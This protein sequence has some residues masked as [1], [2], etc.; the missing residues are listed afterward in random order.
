ME[1]RV[2]WKEGLAFEGRSQGFSVP[3]DATP[4]LGHYFGPSPK[5]LLVLALAGCAGMDVM[6]VLK[7]N[8]QFIDRFEVEANAT[9]TTGKHP[10]VF[11]S[12]DL[13]FKFQGS[14][15]PEIAT[16]AVEL[17]QTLYSGVS[18]MICQSAPINWILLINGE[19]RGQGRANFTKFEEIFQSTFEG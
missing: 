19:K 8:K 15:D 14:I 5:E 6:G 11:S 17:S 16:Q 1:T 13:I 7:K 9:S 12:V 18:A 4:P 3:M 10:L 2:I